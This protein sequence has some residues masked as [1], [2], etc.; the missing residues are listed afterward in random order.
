MEPLCISYYWSKSSS[1]TQDQQNTQAAAYKMKSH[2]KAI[3]KVSLLITFSGILHYS[4]VLGAWE[5][6]ENRE[7]F[8]KT[9]LRGGKNPWGEQHQ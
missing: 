2:P 3:F 9:M 8:V 7:N 5:M 4:F 1:K 6:Q